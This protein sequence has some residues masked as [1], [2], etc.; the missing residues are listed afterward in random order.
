ME[1][2]SIA[3]YQIPG[4]PA[5]ADGSCLCGSQHEQCGELLLYILRLLPWGTWSNEIF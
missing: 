2:L 5:Q 3:D 4:S 1:I